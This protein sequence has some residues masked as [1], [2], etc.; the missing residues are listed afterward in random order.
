MK[1]SRT[2]FAI[3]ALLSLS[4]A[5]AQTPEEPAPLPESRHRLPFLKEEAEK[6]GIELPRTFGIGLVYYHLDRAI[7]VSDVRVGRNGATPGSVSD[8]AHLGSSSKVD[9]VNLKLDMWLLPFLNLYAIA[10]YLHNESTTNIDVT[11]PPILPN[12]SPREFT[13]SVPTE[14]DGTVGGLGMTLAGGY[15]PFMFAVDVNADQADLGFDDKFKAVVTSIRAGWNGTAGSRPLRVWLNGTYWDTFA[16]AT[17]TVADPDG[18]TLEFEVDQGPEHPW[19]YGL[20]LSYSAKPWLE[21]SLD[22]GT[23]FDGGWYV[24]L[25]PVFRF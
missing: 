25:V 8:F 19:T 15:G 16:T 21:L 1:P 20:G 13:F 22:S 5:N 4:L 18:G 6:R 3:L 9:N 11:L 23:D 2:A 17:G 24:A 12:G 7:D 10:G 14:I